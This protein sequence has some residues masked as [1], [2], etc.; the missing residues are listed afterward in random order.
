MRSR[1]HARSEGFELHRL[2]NLGPHY[3]RTIEMWHDNW[4]SNKAEVI[5]AY[6]VR[7]YRLWDI[8]LA[9]S[10]MIARQGTSTVYMMTCHKNMLADGHSISVKDGSQPK[11]N[12]TKLFIGDKP[13]AYQQ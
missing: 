1:T 13:I 8:F 6:K 11:L 7:W 2:Q 10:T 5:A 9:W 4:V 12:R 3:A